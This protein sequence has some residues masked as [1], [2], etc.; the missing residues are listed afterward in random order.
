MRLRHCSRASGG[1]L[2]GDSRVSVRSRLRLCG[3]GRG[4]GR[5]EEIEEGKYEA[6]KAS[7]GRAF[8]VWI[9]GDE[10]IVVISIID[11]IT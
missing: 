3:N 11:I 4:R 2:E 7:N 5:V 1:R 8:A 6:R 10:G 9:C